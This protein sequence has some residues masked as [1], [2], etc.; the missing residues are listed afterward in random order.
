MRA[1]EKYLDRNRDAVA[2]I[3]S[4]K[5]IR[6]RFF[7]APCKQDL[8]DEIVKHLHG[9]H[10]CADYTHLHASAHYAAMVFDGVSDRL[11]VSCT[12]ERIEVS[13]SNSPT[14]FNRK[15]P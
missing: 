3:Q 6:L 1:L 8:I 7:D 12:K 9:R 4:E 2:P 10:G 11:P 14:I 5:G 15:M 13:T